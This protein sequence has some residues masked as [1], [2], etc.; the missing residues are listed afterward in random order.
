MVDVLQYALLG[1][2][3]GAVYALLGTGVVLV[4]R[5]SGVLNFAQGAVAMVTAY[6]FV[7]L[8]QYHGWSVRQPPSP[9]RPWPGSWSSRPSERSAGDRTRRSPTR[10]CPPTSGTKQVWS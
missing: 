7:D 10:F 9:S 2:G 1:L 5:G 8:T 3:P 4:Y 6:I